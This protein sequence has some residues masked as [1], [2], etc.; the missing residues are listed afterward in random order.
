MTPLGTERRDVT[1]DVYE[2]EGGIEPKGEPIARWTD[3]I[4]VEWSDESA[5]FFMND[6]SMCLDTMLDRSDQLEIFDRFTW[7]RLVSAEG[8]LCIHVHLK[9]RKGA[10]NGTDD[11]G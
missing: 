10:S 9:V 2:S 1:F 3:D 7:N 11:A 8:C 5:E 4:P 6:S